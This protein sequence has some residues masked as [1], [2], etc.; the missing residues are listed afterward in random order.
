MIHLFDWWLI[1]THSTFAIWHDEMRY[2]MMRWY[3]IWYDEMIWWDDLI[4]FDETIIK[5]CGGRDYSVKFKIHHIADLLKHFYYLISIFN[6]L[7]TVLVPDWSQHITS[8]KRWMSSLPFVFLLAYLSIFHLTIYLSIYL[9]MYLS[10]YL[11]IYIYIY[12]FIC[13]SIYLPIHLSVCLSI[14][15]SIYLSTYLSIYLPIYLSIYLPTYLSIY[16][17]IY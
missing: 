17:S 10:I 16:L 11:S 12:L 13:L 2:D 6:D 8:N 3:E 7:F 9:S 15:P 1:F 14:H 4:W 5:L